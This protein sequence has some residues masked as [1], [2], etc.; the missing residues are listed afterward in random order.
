MCAYPVHSAAIAQLTR[1]TGSS[2]LDARTGPSTLG[3]VK[4]LPRRP[5]DIETLNFHAAVDVPEVG[6]QRLVSDPDRVQATVERFL[7]GLRDSLATPSRMRGWVSDQ[8]FGLIAADLDGCLMVK[9][10]DAGTLFHEDEVKVPDWRLTLRSSAN[11]LVEVK[12]VDEV[13]APLI[14]KLRLRE[15][16]RLRRYAELNDCPLYIAVHWVALDQWNLVA[17]DCFKRVGDH[18][19]LD[20]STA[21]KRD[22][23]GAM[24]ND[25]WLGLIPP[26]VFR[27][28]MEG[29]L[30]PDA[31]GPTP[32]AEAQPQDETTSQLEGTIT[33]V[34]IECGGQTMIGQPE[35][36]LVWFLIQHARWPVEEQLRQIGD[37]IFEMVVTMA[38]DQMPAGQGF[39]FVG[40]LSELYTRM[41]FAGTSM[42]EGTRKLTIDVEPGTLP[43]LV[44]TNF[45][46]NRLPLW[47]FRILPAQGDE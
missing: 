7:A 34:T 28:R 43:R 15:V 10:E 6:D 46:S 24:L 30:T 37:G 19:E 25:G 14:A 44:P 11:A 33:D 23:M 16:A 21:A 5:E 29:T 9:Q 8:L 39:A 31:P 41:F 22:H 45:K 26:L 47:R 42:R 1:S 27:L 12:A 3:L 35:R 36:S 32:G 13:S 20:L 17:I 2:P 40:R 38:P 18:F 4:R